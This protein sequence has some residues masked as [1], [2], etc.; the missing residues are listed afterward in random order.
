[1]S[2]VQKGVLY[3]HTETAKQSFARNLA[4]LTADEYEVHVHDAKPTPT[5]VELAKL[6]VTKGLRVFARNPSMTE[7]LN[8]AGIPAETKMFSLVV[9]GEMET[10]VV[11]L[12]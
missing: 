11:G 10:P 9:R 2:L 12:H 8:E 6:A 5:M 7:A 3:L 4:T 1:M